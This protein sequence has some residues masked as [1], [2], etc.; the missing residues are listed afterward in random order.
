MSKID[1]LIKKLKKA[2][3]I[4]AKDEIDDKIK[5]KMMEEMNRRGIG[6]KQIADHYR[7][8]DENIP[9]K[10]RTNIKR[11]LKGQ[12]Q[13]QVKAAEPKNPS[14]KLT[15]VKTVDELADELIKSLNDLTKS[16]YGPKG[17]M[18]YNPTDNIKR[19]AKN[20]G[21]EV[22]DIGGNKNV[23]ALS[24]KPGQLSAKAQAKLEAAKDKAKSAKMPVKTFS[25]EEIAE[26]NAKINAENNIKKSLPHWNEDELAVALAGIAP[27]N[28]SSLQ[29]SNSEF[30]QIAINSG[31]AVTQQQANQLE[32]TWDHSIHNWFAEASKPISS[33][34]SSQEEEEQYWNNIKINDTDAE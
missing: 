34:F 16:N 23:K 6:G 7:D 2:K 1:K 28:R 21:D 32:K 20:T 22:E 11:A 26:M 13:K 3:E 5:A 12:E 31:M 15:V 8:I 14:P 9:A 24:T 10:Q 33:R 29:P 25:P 17:M 4:M 18:L 30:E 19:K 27:L